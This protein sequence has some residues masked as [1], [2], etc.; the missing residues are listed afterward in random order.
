MR[1]ENPDM[2]ILEGGR[3]ERGRVGGPLTKY[4]TDSLPRGILWL[5]GGVSR[6]TNQDPLCGLDSVQFLLEGPSQSEP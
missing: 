6:S 3:T 1:T 5:V 4:S 2:W